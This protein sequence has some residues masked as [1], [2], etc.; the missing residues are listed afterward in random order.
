MDMTDHA[1]NAAVMQRA[2]DA[3]SAG[4][5]EA[6]GEIWAPDI[7]WHQPPGEGPLSGDFSGIET[8]L[9][10]FGRTSELSDGTFRA[11]ARAVMG[12]TGAAGAIMRLTAERNGQALD[13][14]SILASS[15]VD[16]KMAEVWHLAEDPEGFQA[17]FA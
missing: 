1:A 6:F 8:V 15:I 13:V 12:G 7:A 4:D 16:G 5:M 9:A 14:T 17:F 2:F 11:E 3:F 10:M